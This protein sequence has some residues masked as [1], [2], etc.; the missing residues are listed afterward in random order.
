M[1]TREQDNALA[2][3]ST[4][5]PERV[6]VEP[7][8]TGAVLATGYR[9]GQPD[10]TY[11]VAQDGQHAPALLPHDRKDTMPATYTRDADPA[12][13]PD[14]LTFDCMSAAGK[15]IC[16]AALGAGLIARGTFEEVTQILGVKLSPSPELHGAGSGVLEVD[17]AD[18]QTRTFDVAPDG[19][20]TARLRAF[21]VTETEQFRVMAESRED[22]L[23]LLTDQGTDA[24]GCDYIGTV[25]RDAEPA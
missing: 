10:Q 24:D 22:A 1:T 25:A 12:Q 15:A 16:D 2:L 6:R 21:I 14:P 17:Y 8:T 5:Y 19:A 13:N 9:H 7:L 20:I 11:W 3:L 23:E 18:G 4:I